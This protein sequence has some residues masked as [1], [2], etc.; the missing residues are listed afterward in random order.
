MDQPAQ[1]PPAPD[2]TVGA[3]DFPAPHRAEDLAFLRNLR[4]GQG[5]LA[6]AG[7]F[8]GRTFRRLRH[9]TSPTNIG[10]ALLANLAA[11]DFGYL[12]LGRLIQRTEATSPPCFA[13][14]R[15]R[16]HFYNWYDT[17]TLK[18]LLPLYVSSVDSGNLAGHLL[19]LG[20]GL[21]ELVDAKIF[22]PQIFAGSARHRGSFA[23]VGR[24]RRGAVATRRRTGESACHSARG[25][26]GLAAG[27]RAGDANFCGA[28]EPGDGREGPRTL[29]AELRG[30]PGRIALSCAM[31]IADRARGVFARRIGLAEKL[32]QLDS[33]PLQLR[34][35]SAFD[36][37][38]CSAIGRTG[39]AVPWSA[40]LHEVYEMPAL[41]E[42]SWPLGSS[43]PPMRRTG[44]DGFH[45]LVRFRRAICSRSV[46]TS[47]KAGV[48]LATT[49]CW[50][51]RHGFAAM[52]PSRKGQVPQDH[53]FS[54]GRLLVASR[55]DP[56]WFRGAARCSSI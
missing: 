12:S 42:R 27:S 1:R 50:P 18:P 31:V 41:R 55:G 56:Y 17:R 45:L 2:L 40:P 53:W 44:R 3:V 46:S 49:I 15:H 38:L 5:K 39:L 24:G 13:L 29:K 37:T 7:Q 28:G 47:P 8:S 34:E 23:E 36:Q 6:A 10:L 22:D 19:T 20:A 11:R 35:I 32:A 26:R 43:R 51:L 9:R 16:G 48:T 33:V 54:L 25:V 30:A 52:S 14:E 4:H 21:R